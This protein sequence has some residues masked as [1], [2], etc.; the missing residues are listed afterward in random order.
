MTE[1]AFGRAALAAAEVETNVSDDF[2]HPCTE[3]GAGLK[4][5]KTTKAHDGRFL[6]DVI[7]VCAIG[8][9]AVGDQPERAMM[10][11]EEVCKV[12]DDNAQLQEHGRTLG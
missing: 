11:R 10:T 3:V 7:S 8:H 6:Q 12:H 5:T 2:S 4:G 9:D 1:E